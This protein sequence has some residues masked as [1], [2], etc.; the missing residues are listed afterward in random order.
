[1]RSKEKR[2]EVTNQPHKETL[3]TQRTEKNH[4]LG[5][6]TTKGVPDIV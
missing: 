3:K 6:Q 5:R 4:Q 1:M 2:L